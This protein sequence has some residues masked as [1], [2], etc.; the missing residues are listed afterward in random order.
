MNAEHI[1]GTRR[2]ER[3]R[4][5]EAQGPRHR[6]LVMMVE[7]DPDDR[8]IYGAILC[9]NGFD[10]VLAPDGLSA[11]RAARARRPDLIVLDLGLPD[12][13]GLDICRTLSVREEGGSVPVIALSGF[14][15]RD[16]GQPARSAGCDLYIEKPTSPL[17]ILREIEARLGRPPV[18][19]VGN[20]PRLIDA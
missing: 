1:V 13:N 7:D 12:G 3:R 14:R 16:M 17:R 8:R 10:V 18:P 19:G 11:V 9:Y 5:E 2:S 4:Q 20:P 6:P 15:E